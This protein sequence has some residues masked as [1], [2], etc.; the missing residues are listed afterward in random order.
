MKTFFAKLVGLFLL[1]VLTVNISAQGWKVFQYEQKLNFTSAAQL[2]AEKSF[3]VGDKGT[4]IAT[5]NRGSTWHKIGLGTQ[6]KIN[7]IKF[8]ADQYTG[9][10]VGDNG[11]ILKTDSR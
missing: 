5:N 9:F 3:V 4:L 10:V 7:S 1:A 11:L 8:L 6:L 2:S